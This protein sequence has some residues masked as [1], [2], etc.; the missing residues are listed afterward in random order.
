MLEV[1]VRLVSEIPSRQEATLAMN[2]EKTKMIKVNTR[3]LIMYLTV[4]AVVLTLGPGLPE[5]EGAGCGGTE[6]GLTDI[7]I[8]L[9]T[10]ILN[11][12]QTGY[13]SD[14]SSG[15]SFHNGVHKI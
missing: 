6:L 3:I 10:N 9:K 11:M 12:W 5:P 8:L 1:L 15:L 14:F 7:S 13:T 4:L 2:I